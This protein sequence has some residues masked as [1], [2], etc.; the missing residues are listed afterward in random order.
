MATFRTHR[1]LAN[2]HNEF[3]QKVE[4]W[5]FHRLTGTL[6]EKQGMGFQN[7]KQVLSSSH[8]VDLNYKKYF[9]IIIPN[10]FMNNFL[11]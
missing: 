7:A 9:R 1:G 8:P 5:G 6:P 11:I 10:I 4:E 3:K 2:T